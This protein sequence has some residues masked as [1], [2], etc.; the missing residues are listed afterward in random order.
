MN[1]NS[2]SG[3]R[4]SQPMSTPQSPDVPT[5]LTTPRVPSSTISP[6]LTPPRMRPLRRSAGPHF[7]ARSRLT[8]SPTGSVGLAPT[9]LAISRTSTA[10]GVSPDGPMARSPALPSPVRGPNTGRCSRRPCPA[11]LLSYTSSISTRLS[12]TATSSTL[13]HLSPTQQME[14][15]HHKRRDASGSEIEYSRR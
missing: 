7:P 6:R 12:S 10:S 15:H 5:T 4:S 1:Q 2:S 3:A 9:L 13:R 8:L 14:Q 11:P